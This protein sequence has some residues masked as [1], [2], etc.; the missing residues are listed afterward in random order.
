MAGSN[1]N[2]LLRM[3]GG[4][5][6]QQRSSEELVVGPIYIYT[7]L[8]KDNTEEFYVSVPHQSVA[9]AKLKLCV[10]RKVFYGFQSE[11]EAQ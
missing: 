1:E 11:G 2:I 10:K 3:G 4:A 9:Q 6:R 7:T 5:E 8:K